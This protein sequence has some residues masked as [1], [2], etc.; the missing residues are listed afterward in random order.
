MQFYGNLT[1]DAQLKNARQ[2]GK[3]YYEFTVIEN[4]GREPNR[5]STP[6]RV[7]AFNIPKEVGERLKK[8]QRVSIK[9]TLTAEP[10]MGQDNK[11]RATLHVVTGLVE[12]QESRNAGGD[13]SGYSERRSA[14]QS[15][16]APEPATAGGFDDDIDDDIP[17]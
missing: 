10:W 3:P 13:E 5:T 11:P 15:S 12:I 2:S 1:A 4:Q 14:P 17:F 7:R 16:R 9:G 8:G 6:Y